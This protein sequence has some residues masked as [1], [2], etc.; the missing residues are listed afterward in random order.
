MLTHLSIVY[1]CISGSSHF[2]EDGFSKSRNEHLPAELGQYVERTD[3]SWSISSAYRVSPWLSLDPYWLRFIY[4]LAGLL[5]DYTRGRGQSKK[6]SEAGVASLRPGHQSF[7]RLPAYNETAIGCLWQTNFDAYG[8]EKHLDV[9]RPKPSRQHFFGSSPVSSTLFKDLSSLKPGSKLA[10]LESPGDV[11]THAQANGFMRMRGRERD[12]TQST[13]TSRDRNHIYI[14]TRTTAQSIHTQTH[15]GLKRTA[16]SPSGVVNGLSLSHRSSLQPCGHVID[17]ASAPKDIIWK[18]LNLT[19][20]ERFRSSIVKFL[21]L[22]VLL[23]INAVSLLAV[24]LIIDMP[25]FS[26]P[27]YL[28]VRRHFGTPSSITLHRL[29]HQARQSL[30]S[31][32]LKRLVQILPLPF[33]AI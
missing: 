17:L 14:H 18:N 24:S 7:L 6:A 13:H 31:A 33:L 22:C 25:S 23:F 9:H 15:L 27:L 4:L 8:L 2:C 11:Y 21:L 20:S 10:G 29:I 3:R 26:R 16:T 1:C 12:S 30:P 5:T 32:S 28:R 19:Q